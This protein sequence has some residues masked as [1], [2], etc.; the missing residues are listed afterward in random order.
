MNTLYCS[1]LTNRCQRSYLIQYM[2]NPVKGWLALGVG[3]SV[4]VIYLMFS[5]KPGEKQH[6]TLFANCP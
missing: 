3:N 2:Q 6:Q 1:S 5:S 4:W